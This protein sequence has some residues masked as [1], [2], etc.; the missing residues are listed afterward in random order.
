ME[1]EAIRAEMTVDELLSR[2]P[3]TARVFVRHRMACVGCD[4]ARFE[5]FADVGM[6]Y[7]QPLD[8]ILERVMN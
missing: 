6:V 7:A 4:G 1:I 3:E 5:S 8:V 2:Y